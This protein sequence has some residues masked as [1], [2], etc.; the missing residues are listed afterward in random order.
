MD[1]RSATLCLPPADAATEHLIVLSIGPPSA[2]SLVRT[3]SLQG[4]PDESFFALVGCALRFRHVSL[5]HR[6]TEC[7]NSESSDVSQS[8]EF[9]TLLSWSKRRMVMRMPSM[10]QQAYVSMYCQSHS[11]LPSCPSP[12][13][14]FHPPARATLPETRV[15]QALLSQSSSTTAIATVVSFATASPAYR[16]RM[17][18]SASAGVRAVGQPSCSQRARRQRR[19]V[20][21]LLPGF[22][23]QWLALASADSVTAAEW[24]RALQLH[25]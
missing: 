13:V 2:W 25:R 7:G 9:L 1:G 18:V 14:A 3:C 6:Q 10:I 23:G 11:S 19:A 21:V 12:N 22:E 24:R 20:A 15:H 4:A 8:G 5:V 16:E 17:P